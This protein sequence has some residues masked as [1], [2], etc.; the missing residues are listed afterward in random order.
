MPRFYITPKSKLKGCND[1]II[2]E[3]TT[4]DERMA[5]HKFLS[6]TKTPIEEAWLY[7]IIEEDEYNK[8][9]EMIFDLGFQSFQAYFDNT[10]MRY[11]DG[12]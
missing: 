5:L 1:N 11:T 10:E 12:I 6:I 8:N 9:K 2:C 3:L 7:D 4:E